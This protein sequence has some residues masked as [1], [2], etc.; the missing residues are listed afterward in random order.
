MSSS[1]L[2]FLTAT[3][4]TRRIR[5]REVSAREMMEA[6][7]AHIEQVNPGVNVE[8]WNAGYLN[9]EPAHYRTGKVNVKMEPAP[10]V[11]SAQMCPPCASTN[12]LTI[13]S[14]RPAPPVDRVREGSARK[15]RSKM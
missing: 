2:C 4:L 6:H 3:E 13:V 1:E 14:P 10:N 11:L 12:C 8:R 5:S 15:K 7:L 9:A